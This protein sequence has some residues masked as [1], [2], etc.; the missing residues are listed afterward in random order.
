MMVSY[1][2]FNIRRLHINEMLF[3]SLDTDSTLFRPTV[4]RYQKPNFSDS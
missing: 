3:E 4:Q 2:P 1:L